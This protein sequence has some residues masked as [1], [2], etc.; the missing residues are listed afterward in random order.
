M[1]FRDFVAFR[2]SFKPQQHSELHLLASV[3]YDALL[4]SFHVMGIQ[5]W[6]DEGD[7]DRQN[8]H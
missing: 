6:T 7:H 2:P 3:L 8:D 4:A 1:P 5:P